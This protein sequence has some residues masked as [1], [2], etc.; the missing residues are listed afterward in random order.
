MATKTDS[1]GRAFRPRRFMLHAALVAGAFIMLYPLLWLASASV[2][3]STL[4]FSDPS[5][6]PG[7][8]RLQ[9]YVEGWHGAANSFGVFF[10]N[11]F[12]IATL[13]VIGNTLAC[14]LVAYAFARL[15]FAFKKTL[16]ALMLV[17][18]MLPLHATLIPQYILF[19]GLGWIN[20]ILPIVVPKFLA[21]DAFFVFL[22]VQFIRGIPRELD[23]AAAI[24]GAG[25]IRIYVSI[26]LPLLSPALVTTAVFS[27][28]W[29]YEDFLTPLV[30]LTSID[31]YT[32]PQG[33]RLFMASTGVSAWG[34]MLAMSL[35]SLVPLF[36]IFFLFQRRLIEGI[37]TTGLKG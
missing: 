2:K 34:P 7:E 35:L 8:I 20:T 3:P 19:N 25:P 29:T 6:I 37:A 4:I 28:L 17:T 16:F 31:N 27:F 10:A 26:I 13:A 1:P 11:S 18:I 21:V 33:L 24:D 15:E 5:L 23:E 14:S 22:M 36:V 32:V 9:N 12:L 30:Y